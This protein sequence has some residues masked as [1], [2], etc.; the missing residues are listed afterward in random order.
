M[1]SNLFF[2]VL[3][4]D[5]LDANIVDF[6]GDEE[7]L[8][9]P[10]DV[11]ASYRHDSKEQW[12]ADADV[13]EELVLKDEDGVLVFSSRAAALTASISHL[14]EN[15]VEVV[16]AN[17]NRLRSERKRSLPKI[18]KRQQVAKAAN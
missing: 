7:R 11:D 15:I 10:D 3:S 2:V 1:S 13:D 14:E 5:K 9:V 18:V 4:E 6:N 16:K 17:V 12:E 8:S